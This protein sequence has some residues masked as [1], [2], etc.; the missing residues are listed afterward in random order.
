MASDSM[1]NNDFDEREKMLEQLWNRSHA[2][3]CS[4][5]YLSHWLLGGRPLSLHGIFFQIF[6]L[7]L[8]I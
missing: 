1:D 7:D 6:Q 8:L 4:L 3:I 2:M 5:T